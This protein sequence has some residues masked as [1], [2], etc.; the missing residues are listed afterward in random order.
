MKYYNSNHTEILYR[1]QRHSKKS[2]KKMRKKL[3]EVFI[4]FCVIS[5]ITV[6]I[7]ISAVIFVRSSS[8]FKVSNVTVV[9]SNNPDIVPFNIFDCFLGTHILSVKERVIDSIIAAEYS[10][11]GL[12]SVIR[13]YPSNIKI[14]LYKKIPVIS[15]ND[16]YTV[17]QDFSMKPIK[18]DAN[19]IHMYTDNNNYKTAFDIPGFAT[20]FNSLINQ[21]SSIKK[22]NF[23]KNKYTVYTY[24]GITII[25]KPG[26]ILPPI[27]QLEGDFK[28]VD[29]RF[30]NSIFVKK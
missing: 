18:S 5:A 6:F 26:N 1:Q 30:R 24:N 8:M 2:K 20:I 7:V 22:I 15:V 23:K 11:Y 3:N 14:I 28:Y 17:Y 12:R 29:V 9:I 21:K 25:L 10:H 27:D 13:E 4:R 19:I 16:K